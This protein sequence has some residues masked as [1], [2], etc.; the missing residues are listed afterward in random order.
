MTIIQAARFSRLHEQDFQF[1]R[2]SPRLSL[3]SYP[4]DSRVAPSR[5]D[6]KIVTAH[7]LHTVFLWH[8]VILIVRKKHKTDMLHLERS[9]F[10]AQRESRAGRL[11][12]ITGKGTFF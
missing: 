8:L 12:Y 9:I 3:C 10:V 4:R 1:P 2:T 6:H 7:K 5:Q 11:T